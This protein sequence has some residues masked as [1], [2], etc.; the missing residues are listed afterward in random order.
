[1]DGLQV[2]LGASGGAGSA[3]VAELAA[4]GARVRAVSRSGRGEPLPR[5]EYVQSDATGA[6]PMRE[7]CRQAAVVYH[8]VNVP[9]PQWQAKLLPI[10]R[11][12]TDAAAA[13]GAE[14]WGT[15]NP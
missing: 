12:V 10:A 9:Y 15:G 14:V 2:V 8:C 13:A 7:V 5:V 6:A 11:A 3:V 1:M 4:R